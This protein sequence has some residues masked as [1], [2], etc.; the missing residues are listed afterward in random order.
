[1]Q[2]QGADQLKGT[3][4]LQQPSHTIPASDRSA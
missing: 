2:K 3:V 4:T 1:M